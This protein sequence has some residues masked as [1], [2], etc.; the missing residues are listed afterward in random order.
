MREWS[1]SCIYIELLTVSLRKGLGDRYRGRW[2]FNK[3]SDQWEGNPALSAEV[4][5]TMI[6]IKHKSGAEGG[7][8]NH[9]VPMSKEHMEKMFAWSESMCSKESLRTPA[10]TMEEQ[11]NRTKHLEFRAF[12]AT[13][14]TIWTR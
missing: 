7:D 14:W 3:D 5:D 4:D 12:A 11:G 1:S 9:S 13:A 2:H 8:R 10:K 6:A